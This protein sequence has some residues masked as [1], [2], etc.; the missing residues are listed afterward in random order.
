MAGCSASLPAM[1]ALQPHTHVACCHT[2]NRPTAALA[3]A[4]TRSLHSSRS[5]FCA[6]HAAIST[7]TTCRRRHVAAH[8]NY[9][10]LD[11]QAVRRRHLPCVCLHYNVKDAAYDW[12]RRTQCMRYIETNCSVGGNDQVIPML[13]GDATDQTP[14]DLPSFLFKERIVYLVRIV[15]CAGLR[16]EHYAHIV[17]AFDIQSFSE[18]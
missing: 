16:C 10:R 18:T 2:G 9:R 14:P 1:A 12:A 11:I 4:R 17:R 5:S 3:S 7:Q 15:R 6:G 8:S 13:A